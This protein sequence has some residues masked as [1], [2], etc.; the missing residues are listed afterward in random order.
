MKK[1]KNYWIIA[2]LAC[3]GCISI[4]PSATWAAI[5]EQSS[6]Y[7]PG[8]ASPAAVIQTQEGDVTGDKKLDT[9]VLKGQKMDPNSGF[10]DKLFIEVNNAADNKKSEVTL[11]GGYTPKMRLCDFNGDKIDDV[12]VSAAT[13]GSGGYTDT[14]IYSFKKNKPV[15]LGVPTPLAITGSFEDNY[16]V[17]FIIPEQKKTVFVDVKDHKDIYDQAGI[18]L[19]N[20]VVKPTAAMVGAFSELRPIDADK[21]GICELVGIQRISGVYNA[22]TIAYGLSLWKYDKKKWKLMNSIVVKAK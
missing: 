21:D 7:H 14:Y 20:K 15:S 11:Q 1:I 16:V 12:Y 22:D 6:L 2:T 5:S 19:N 18:Y 3:I 9:V 10:Y 8:H 4:L 17:K 13:G